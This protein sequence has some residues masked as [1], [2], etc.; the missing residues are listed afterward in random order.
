MR[1]V[2]L[3]TS[4]LIRLYI[5]DGPFPDGLEEHLAAAWRA[6]TTLVIPELALVEIAQVLWKKEKAGKIR[7][8]ESQEIIAAVMDLPLEVVGHRTFLMDSLT[9]ARRHGL[10]VYDAVFLSLAAKRG[11]EL[12]TADSR[13]KK[14]FIDSEKYI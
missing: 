1:I 3:D 10:T 7:P 2:V 12:V 11:A 8:S 14:A 4:A 9:F 5:P 6:E 13:L